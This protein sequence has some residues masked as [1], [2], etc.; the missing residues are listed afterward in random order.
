[1]T[2]QSDPGGPW[3]YTVEAGRTLSG[4]LPGGPAGYDF[5][6]HG[7]NGFVRRFAGGAGGGPE[8][9]ACHDGRS[10]EVR[11]TLTNP[12][13]ATIRLTVADAYG[14]ERATHVLR[15]GGRVVD[16]VN[17][18]RANGWYDISVTS[19]RDARFLRRLAGHVETG[20]PS[21]SDPAI[22]AD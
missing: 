19:D 18:C 14:K 5:T 1:M 3:T 10:G 21:T 4:D 2:S 6:A 7:P 11:L 12:G 20:R 13:A 22:I 15:P 16:T 9:S 8:V 17:T